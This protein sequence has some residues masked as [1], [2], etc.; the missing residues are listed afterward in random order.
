MDNLILLNILRFCE[1]REARRMMIALP[2][3]IPEA[4]HVGIVEQISTE[5]IKHYMFQIILNYR[6]DVYDYERAIKCIKR[7]IHKCNR[8]Y[9]INVCY[10]RIDV[11]VYD[12]VAAEAILNMLSSRFLRT[13]I[14]DYSLDL[15]FEEGRRHYWFSKITSL[16]DI[17]PYTIILP[18]KNKKYLVT[19][20]NKV[21]LLKN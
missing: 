17:K 18:M 5:D 6:C 13:I 9:R 10:N 15:V 21:M 8:S 14:S 2:T 1:N 20:G 7:T 11:H 4:L 16:S 19:K 3:L 12:I